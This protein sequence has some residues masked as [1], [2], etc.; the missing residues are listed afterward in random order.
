M[1]R[2]LFKYTGIDF[3]ALSIVEDLEQGYFIVNVDKKENKEE[4]IKRIILNI[5][6]GSVEL[7]TAFSFKSKVSKMKE[8]IIVKD[9]DGNV[10][11]NAYNAYMYKVI[12]NFDYL[13]CHFRCSMYT[14]TIGFYS[15]VVN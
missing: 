12:D 10:V 7:G 8:H 13:S 2:L 4:D 6:Q 11:A 3:V 5:F 15:E 1:R 14:S 9:N